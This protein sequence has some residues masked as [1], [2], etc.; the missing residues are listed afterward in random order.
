MAPNPYEH[1]ARKIK[2]KQMLNMNMYDW[3]GMKFACFF[4]FFVQQSANRILEYTKI[5]S[6]GLFLSSIPNDHI[7]KIFLV[8]EQFFLNR[9]STYFELHMWVL[10]TWL[11]LHFPTKLMI[12]CKMQR[13]LQFELFWKLS[14]V[15]FSSLLFECFYKAKIMY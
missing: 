2:I 15:A 11:T 1:P 6:G 14:L 8:N 9:L 3:E 4:F 7:R 13:F 10:C 5:Y 12:K